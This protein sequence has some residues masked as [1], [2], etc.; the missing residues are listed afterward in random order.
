MGMIVSDKN[1]RANFMYIRGKMIDLLSEEY[2][3]ASED[4]ISKAVFPHIL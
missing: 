4:Y 3:K 1:L 2:N